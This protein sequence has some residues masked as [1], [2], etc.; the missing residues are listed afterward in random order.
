[1]GRNLKNLGQ[2]SK[3]VGFLSKNKPNLSQFM[4]EKIRLGNY[5]PYTK[6]DNKQNMDFFKY[7]SDK[8]VYEGEPFVLIDYHEPVQFSG[9]P[10]NKE[11]LYFN[12]FKTREK[13]QQKMQSSL[14]KKY[15]SSIEDQFS[16]D[17]KSLRHKKVKLKKMIMPGQMDLTQDKNNTK[18]YPILKTKEDVLINLDLSKADLARGNTFK[19]L[20]CFSKPGKIND[21]LKTNQDRFFMIQQCLGSSN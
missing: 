8:D 10:F 20:Y 7:T 21:Q 3:N 18:M 14:D 16:R 15:E 1:M 17:K 19:N 5:V 2:D 13:F 12:P 4:D 9:N 6:V 11:D